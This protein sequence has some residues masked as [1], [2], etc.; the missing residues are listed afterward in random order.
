[1]LQF[2]I[3][4][5]CIYVLKQEILGKLYVLFFRIYSFELYKLLLYFCD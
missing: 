5:D 3:A 2:R 1:M 4:Y